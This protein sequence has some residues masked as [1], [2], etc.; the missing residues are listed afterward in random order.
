MVSD[1][2]SIVVWSSQSQTL[3]LFSDETLKANEEML[4]DD[5]EKEFNNTT[6]QIEEEMD[7]QS[8]Q[9]YLQPSTSIYSSLSL[10]LSLSIYLS[11]YLSLSLYLSYLSIYLSIF[12]SLAFQMD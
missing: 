2:N 6:S 5:D 1:S 9:N 3:F 11:I 10:S 12:L 7:T 4:P 8:E